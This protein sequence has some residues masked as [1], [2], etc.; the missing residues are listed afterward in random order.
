MAMTLV[1]ETYGSF[2]KIKATWVEAS[3]VA[4]A[5]TTNAYNGK[6]QMLVTVPDGSSAPAA[7]YDITVKDQSSVDVLA[8]AGANR[9]SAST[10]TVLSASMGA[11][12]NDTLAF[13]VANAGSSSGAGTIYLFIR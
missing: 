12:A 5:T 11:V 4:T 3:A 1:E 2:K 7:N 8:G 9:S 13:A 6:V 10:E